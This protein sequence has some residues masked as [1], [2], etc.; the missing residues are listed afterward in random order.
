MSKRL[1]K[2]RKSLEST[3]SN[4]FGSAKHP[5]ALASAQSSQKS[6]MKDQPHAPGYEIARTQGKEARQKVSRSELGRWEIKTDRQEA[7]D[8]LFAQEQSRLAD[9]IDE[10]HKR[11][12]ANPFAFYRATAATM[13][14][15]LATQPNTGIIVQACGDAHIANFGGYRSPESNLVFDLNDFDETSRAPWEWDVKRLVAS[16][17][18][19]GRNRGFSDSWCL[20][21]AQLTAESYRA[22]MRYFAERGA[23]DVWNAYIDVGH[24]LERLSEHVSKDDRRHVAADLKRAFSKTN[25]RAFDKLVTTCDGEVEMVYDPPEIV[26]LSHFLTSENIEQIRSSI[27]SLL[28]GYRATLLPTYRPLLENYHLLGLAQKVVG[29]GSV[30][31][32]CWVAVLT[33]TQ[34]ADPLVLQIKEANASVLE[35]WCGKSPYATH[36]ERVIQGQRLMQATSGVLLGWTTGPGF[37][38]ISRDYYIRQLWNW[39]MSV[40]LEKISSDELEIYSLLCAWTLARAHARTGNRGAIAGYLGASE[41]FDEAMASFAVAYADQND[42][43]YQAFLSRIDLHA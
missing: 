12:A 23:L 33:G 24:V 36:G 14:A 32:R 26:P 10:R 43:D 18:I 7:M 19:C 42:I 15:D 38:G 35:R 27:E 17:V 25:Q 16:V 3:S 6:G 28:K 21:A 34:I 41:K 40:D 31:T 13:A 4:A 22:A 1:A 39:K 37:D 5:S 29:V 11:M 2:L 8:L 9:L 20:H 30:G